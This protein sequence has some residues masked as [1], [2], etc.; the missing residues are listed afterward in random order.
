MNPK[1]ETNILKPFFHEQMLLINVINTFWK[2][3]IE[4][5]L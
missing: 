4:Y 2:L 3:Y 5:I 1:N